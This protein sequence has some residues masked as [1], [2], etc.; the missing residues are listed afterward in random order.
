ME[1]TETTRMIFNAMHEG[2]LIVDASGSIVFS[3][4]AYR[5]F[6]CK[7][8]NHEVEEL[9][10][11][12]LRQLRPGARLPEVLGTGKPILHISRHETRDS[13]FVNMYPL[14]EDGS[15]KGGLSVVTFLE[16][17]YRTKET[18]EAMEIRNKQLLQRISKANGARYTFDDIIAVSPV[19]LHTVHLA[20]RIA[21]TDATVL[22]TGESGT[23]KE[24]YAQAIHNGSKRQSC[25]FVAVNCSNF[26]PGV[27]E[28]ELF[29]YVE[30]AFT[31]AKK[32]GKIGLFEAASGGTL[33]LDEIS[34]M[35][36]G[37]QAKLL[38]VLQERCIRPVGA[39]KEMDVDVRVIAACNVELEHCMEEGR[40]RSDLYYRLN[41]FPISI[42]PLRRRVED[43]PALAEA[44]LSELSHKQ[45][46]KL[47]ITL[48]AMETLCR[49]RWPGNVRELRNV[50]EFSTYLST[51]D[52]IQASAFP[53]N[54]L[55]HHTSCKEMSLCEQVRHFERDAILRRL[56]VNGKHLEGKK[57]TAMELG[58]S[59]ASLYAKLKVF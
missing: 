17:A 4:K 33:F 16:D 26:N 23:G 48:E 1:I 39:V 8:M 47:Q 11:Q 3:N 45:H 25:V 58:I 12:P 56:E 7:E 10:G 38:R 43:I 44:I 13:Y 5:D 54:L 40:F 55:K 42:P 14:Y 41:T 57:K 59:L 34:E 31:G 35:D 29:G 20:E 9:E 22:L 30:G 36:A 46:R 51:E 37:L 2:I 6:L 49:H 18:L 15:L 28:S 52:L 24:L 21:K 53:S 50:L 32:G 19:S 27:L